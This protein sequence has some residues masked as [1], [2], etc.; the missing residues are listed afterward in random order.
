[1]I[2]ETEY[3]YEEL[4]QDFNP[5]KDVANYDGL[6]AMPWVNLADCL[7]YV[8]QIFWTPEHLQY[9]GMSMKPLRRGH[10]ILEDDYHGS[11]GKNYMGILLSTRPYSE[12][13]KTVIKTFD[14]AGECRDFEGWVIRHAVDNYG[15]YSKFKPGGLVTNLSHWNP[16]SKRSL[17]GCVQ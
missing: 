17:R 5:P 6:S 3:I 8:Y 10:S 12:F 14:N 13:T 11:V 2:M 4:E 9:Y 1:M 15:V 7:A 16:K